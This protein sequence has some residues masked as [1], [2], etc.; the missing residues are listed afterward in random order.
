MMKIIS[1]V[2][3]E[4]INLIATLIKQNPN[5]MSRRKK[6]KSLLWRTNKGSRK[7]KNNKN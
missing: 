5:M 7:R 6:Q 2:A 1:K 4:E 3:L